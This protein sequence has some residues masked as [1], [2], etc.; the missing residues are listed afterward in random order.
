[1]AAAVDCKGGNYLLLFFSSRTLKCFSFKKGDASLC[2]SKCFQEIQ[3]RLGDQPVP[4]FVR[5]EAVG[6][7][8]FPDFRKHGI[9]REVPVKVENREPVVFRR[10]ADRVQVFRENFSRL[11]I[12]REVVKTSEAFPVGR[13]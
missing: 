1:M 7:V 10:L 12:G 8:F 13:D 2:R 6:N 5:M 4:F 3:N 9:Q 11:G